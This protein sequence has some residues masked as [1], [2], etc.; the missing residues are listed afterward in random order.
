[1]TKL[2]LLTPLLLIGCLSTKP[3]SQCYE[4]R[5]CMSTD[6]RSDSFQCLDPGTR[7]YDCWDATK[8]SE[9]LKYCEQRLVEK[10]CN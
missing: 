5:W 4:M 6:E 7:S 8:D 9:E 1:M 2:L 10:E 3:P